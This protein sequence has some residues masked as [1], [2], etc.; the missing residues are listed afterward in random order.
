MTQR[1]QHTAE[2][3]AMVALAAIKGELTVAQIT[4]KYE[5]HSAQVSAWKKQALD[6]IAETFKTA[7][8][9]KKDEGPS[10]EQ[11]FSQIGQLKVELDWLKKKSA[12]FE[13]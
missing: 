3:K 4:S 11:L 8:S 2:F 10:Q 7:K 6:Q 12:L 13:K 5:V 1:K 9:K